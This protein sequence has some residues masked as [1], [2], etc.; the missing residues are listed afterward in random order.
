MTKFRK[1]VSGSYP[2]ADYNFTLACSLTKIYY[3]S[4]VNPSLTTEKGENVSFYNIY[5]INFR[6]RSG[7]EICIKWN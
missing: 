4:Y 1:V 5:Y 6:Q 2:D 7:T 3:K